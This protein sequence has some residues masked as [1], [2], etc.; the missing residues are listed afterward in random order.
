MAAG[1]D[2][3][4]ELIRVGFQSICSSSRSWITS[5]IPSPDSVPIAVLA[6]SADEDA[7]ELRSG[8]PWIVLALDAAVHDLRVHARAA[9][10]LPDLVEDQDVEI[11]RNP[12]HPR[13]RRDEEFLFLLLHLLDADGG[14]LRG[15]V[16]RVFENRQVRRGS[17]PNSSTCRPT[18]RITVSSPSL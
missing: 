15:V 9:D 18:V 12:A 13:F 14:Q 4:N 3:V 11:E 17:C 16:V 2:A 1:V 6:D 7:L 8:V 10:V 5:A